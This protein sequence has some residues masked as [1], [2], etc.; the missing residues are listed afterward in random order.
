MLGNFLVHQRLRDERFILLVMSEFSE[1]HHIDHHI[2]A[3]LHAVVEGDATDQ[4]H[5]LRVIGVDMKHRRLD[6][7]GYIGAIQ[8]RT[9]VARI[10]GGEPN[11]IVD[12]DVYRP[13]RFEAACLR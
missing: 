1:A 10:R 3:E 9:R 11:L 7:F 12:D 6:H 2:L 4:Q 5:R 8:R 13:A